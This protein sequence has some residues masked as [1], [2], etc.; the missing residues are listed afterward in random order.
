MIF[1]SGQSLILQSTAFFTLMNIFIKYLDRISVHQIVFSRSI[2]ALSL[3]AYMVKSQG[4]SLLGNNKKLLVFRA[5]IGT[6]GLYLFVYSLQNLPLATAVTLQYLTPI[7]SLFLGTLLLREPAPL[8]V[9]ILSITAFAGVVLIEEAGHYGGGLIVVGILSAVCSA[10]AYNLVRRLRHDDH[11]LVVTLYFPL[12]TVPVSLTP[13]IKAW[14]TPTWK[15]WCLL[16]GVGVFTQMAQVSM[17]KAYHLEPIH[18]IAPLSYLGAVFAAAIGWIL[19]H[20][21]ISMTGWLGLIVIILSVGILS[22]YQ[23]KLD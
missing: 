9:W 15:E 17:T 23:K 21:K 11:P 1:T 14:V 3:A 18:R 22:Q 16:I 20:E 5:L 8:P 6:T 19:F 10:V 4:I 12:V 7:F 2:V 13:T